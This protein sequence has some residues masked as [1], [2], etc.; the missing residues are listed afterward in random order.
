[1][2]IKSS[3]EVRRAFLDFFGAREHTI[4]PSSPLVPANDPTLLFTNAG[5]VQFK[6][7]FLGREQHPFQRAVSCQACVRAGGKHNDLEN[8]GYTARHHTFFEMLGNF[9]FGDYFKREA[10]HYAWEFLTDS[11]GIDPARL[12]IT[13]F[14]D[15]DEAASVWLDEIR[16]DKRRL[17]RCGAEDN[18]WTMGATGP[19]GPCSEIFFDHGAAIAGGP[20]GTAEQNGDRYVEIWNLVFTQ[21]NRDDSGRL[22]PIPHP[23]VDTGMGLERIAAV[24]QGVHSN[25]DID[26][27]RTLTGAVTALVS[28]K[29]SVHRTS[30]QAIADHIRSCA[31]IAAEGVVPS[32]DGR[33]YVLRRI[34]RRAI[35]HG[36]RLGFGEPFFHRLVAVLATE[37]GTVYPGLLERR[38]AIERVLKQE[39]ERFAETLDL[40]LKLLERS[41]ADLSGS[42]IPGRDVFQLY[43]TYGFPVDLTADIARE[44]G[45]TL[46]MEGFEREMEQQRE[47]ARAASPFKQTDWPNP[48]RRASAPLVDVA[49]NLLTSTLAPALA[50]DDPLRVSGS[51]FTGYGEV[52]CESRVVTLYREGERVPALQAG[53]RGVVVLD[54]T[55]FYAE[56]GG[57]VGDIGDLCAREGLFRVSDTQRLGGATLHLGWL[58]T[59]TLK[60]GESVHAQVDPALR[61]ATALNHSATHLLHAALRQVLGTHVIQKGSL[62]APERLRFDF[63][64]TGPLESDELREVERLVNR[65]IRANR[66]VE[67]RIMSVGQALESGALAL[68]GEK[69]EEQVRVLKIGD[70]SVELCGGTHVRHSGD[71]G[72][73]KIVSETGV[74][75]GVRR[76]EAQTGERALAWVTQSDQQLQGIADLLK[77]PREQLSV[78]VEQLLQN[79]KHEEKQNQQL[80]ARLSTQTGR[81]LSEAAVDIAG[82]KVLAEIIDDADPASLRAAMDR[83]KDK[84]SH[85]VIVLASVQSGKVLLVAGVAKDLIRHVKAGDLVNFVAQQVGGKGGGRSDFAQAGGSEPDKLKAALATVSDWVRGQIAP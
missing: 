4:V 79:L 65:E 82:V 18:F 19:C 12:W 27:F 1:M 69:Y 39:E 74:A 81:D 62:V 53:E 52:K 40:G 57:Q 54:R 46:D 50:A 55:P 72:L 7:V 75:A 2:S 68:F 70:F 6:N 44:R 11:L 78:R 76:I 56:A 22:H 24:M 21:Y 29:N 8:V 31:F 49:P 9:S 47:R 84:L 14:Q 83:L 34:I 58:K 51:E 33:G 37:M 30:V 26:V 42:V 13:V 38:A 17:S 85:A 71:I 48:V 66:E 36:H 10:I 25:Y 45:L 64:H 15:D 77:V 63:S 35:R 80:R 20:P 3:S 73:F 59:G 61:R 23:S 16:F 28:D 5:M 67:T 32:N 43:D 60:E 41:I